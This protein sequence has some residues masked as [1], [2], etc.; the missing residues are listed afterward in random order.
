MGSSWTNSPSIA[1]KMLTLLFFFVI[2]WTCLAF[3]QTSNVE[4]LKIPQSSIR[5]QPTQDD[6]NVEFNRIKFENLER[7]NAILQDRLRTLEDKFNHQDDIKATWIPG[8]AS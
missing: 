4:G 2:P 3:D 6:S 8:S 7:E 5:A 1:F